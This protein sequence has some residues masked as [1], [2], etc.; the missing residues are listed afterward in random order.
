MRPGAAVGAALFFLA[1]PRRHR[2]RGEW[3]APVAAYLFTV[4][5]LLALRGVAT[6]SAAQR[7]QL[8]IPNDHRCARCCAGGLVAARQAP[9][10]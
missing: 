6:R 5:E 7:L 2:G 3:G 10:L 1:E 9:P 8:D 4:V